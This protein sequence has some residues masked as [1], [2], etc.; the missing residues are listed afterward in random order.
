MGIIS[1]FESSVVFSTRSFNDCNLMSE[2][3]VKALWQPGADLLASSNM[4]RYIEWLRSENIFDTDGYDALYAWSVDQPAECWT[5]IARFF[6]IQFHHPWQHVLRLPETGMIGTRW[7]EGS[8]LSYAE[9]VFRQRNDDRP[10][11]VFASEDGVLEEV[12]WV[13]MERQVAALAGWM[14]ARGIASGD[15]VVS[16]LPNIPEHVMVFLAANSIGAIWSSCSPDFGVDAIRDRVGQIAP[17]MVILSDGYRYNGKVF[18]RTADWRMLMA[19]LDSVREILTVDLIGAE[20]RLFNSVSWKSAIDF[21][22]TDLIFEPVDFSHPIWILFSSGTTGRPKAITHS[23]G[24][25]L[26]EHLKALGLHQDLKPG[27]RYF[28]YSTTG[29]MMWNYGLSSLLLGATLVLYD[30][31]AGYPD[32]GRLWHFAREARIHHFGGGAA[33]YTACMRSGMSFLP[34]AFPDLRTIGSTGSP[35]PAES[36]EWIYASVKQ[37]VWLISLSGG[38][39]ICSAF[40]GGCPMRPVYAGEIQCRMLGCDVDSFDAKGHPVRGE[41]GE[42]VIRQPMPSMPVYF[43]N[44]PGNDRYVASYFNGFPGVWQHG[45][46][47]ELTERGTLKITGRSDATLNRDGVRIGTAEIYRTLESMQEVADSL[48]VCIDRP[49]GT[50]HMPLFIVLAPDAILDD[51]LR[52]RIKRTLR[53][54]YSPRHVPDEIIQ[55]SAIPYTLSGKKTEKPVKRILMGADPEQVISRDTLRDPSALD[56]FIEAGKKYI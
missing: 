7:F 52:Q 26:I 4:T 15:R 54:K 48:V 8:K 44:D 43:W 28:W 5:S 23:T 55:V 25:C 20:L 2:H 45:D 29:W 49:D 39:D 51:A 9:H 32:L 38:T 53:T 19:E 40:V 37:D 24:G 30:G 18:D 16:L 11:I 46:W 13:M 36:F 35:L 27:E 14:R 22:T 50:Q 33:F 6:D 42:M 56:V 10:A 41:P 34:D 12:S 47:L 17:R 21:P 3:Q 31:S 1:N